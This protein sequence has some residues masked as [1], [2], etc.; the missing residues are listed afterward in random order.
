MLPF[1]LQCSYRSLL[2]LVGVGYLTLAITPRLLH[3]L[4]EILTWH[5]MEKLLYRYLFDLGSSTFD[6]SLNYLTT[7]YRQVNADVNLADK[8][9]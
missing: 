8:T 2:S 7:R 3:C 6:T 9:V 5:Q 1:V 4:A